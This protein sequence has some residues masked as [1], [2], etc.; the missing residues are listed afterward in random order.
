M[1]LKL[2]LNAKEHNLVTTYMSP[3]VGVHQITKKKD[4]EECVSI[5]N[6]GRRTTTC[7]HLIEVV[8]VKNIYLAIVV[9]IPI[10]F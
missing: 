8:M 1:S 2:Y 4:I 9:R 7:Q 6:G 10:I 3:L 5:K